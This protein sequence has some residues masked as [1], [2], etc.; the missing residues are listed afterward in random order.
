VGNLL[1]VL[2]ISVAGIGSALVGLGEAGTALFFAAA[3]VLLYAGFMS[4][5]AQSLLTLR[6]GIRPTR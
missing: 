1:V 4:R 2:G 5:S 3:V 6:P